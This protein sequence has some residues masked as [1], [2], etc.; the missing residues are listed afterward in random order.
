MS[1]D[2][3][4][5][6]KELELE[7]LAFIERSGLRLTIPR[8]VILR[9]VLQMEGPFDAEQLL[10]EARNEDRLISLTTVYRTLPILMQGGIVRKTLH[11][12]DDKQTYELNSDAQKTITLQ[13]DEEGTTLQIA[14]DCLWLRL[15]F[16]AKQ[17]GYIA[18][19]ID[20]RIQAEKA[21]G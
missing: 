21:V 20:I 6:L 15:Q 4:A 16:L 10:A 5:D 18:R 7:C 3:S 17:Q 9:A 8:K 1:I 12:E 14:D 2:L 19:N 11:N 13:C